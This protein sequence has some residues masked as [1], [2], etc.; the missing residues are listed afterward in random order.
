VFAE[1][2]KKEFPMSDGD[3]RAR[4]AAA[5]KNVATRLSELL[6]ETQVVPRKIASEARDAI[7]RVLESLGAEEQAA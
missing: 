3:K 7:A 5:V 2:L 6:A 4:D 1:L